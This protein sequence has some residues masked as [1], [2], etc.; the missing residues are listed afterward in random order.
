ME[1]K[2]DLNQSFIELIYPSNINVLRKILEIWIHILID[3]KLYNF[4]IY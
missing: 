4:H 2:N 3:N 1:V